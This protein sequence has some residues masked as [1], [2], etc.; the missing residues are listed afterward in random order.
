MHELSIAQ[1]LLDQVERVARENGARRIL[2]A[3][4]LIGP[5][6]GVD[7]EALRTAFELVAA[8]TMAAGCALEIDSPRA[9]MRC[10]ACGFDGELPAPWAACGQCGSADVSV[11]GGRELLLRNISIEDEGQGGER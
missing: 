9:R 5:F 8:G 4:L 1:S 11:D 10:A 2:R 3:E 6:S 7:A